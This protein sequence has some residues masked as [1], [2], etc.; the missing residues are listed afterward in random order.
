MTLSELDIQNK[1]CYIQLHV[2]KL[3]NMDKLWGNK[4]NAQI[5]E[6]K[7]DKCEQIDNQ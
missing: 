1:E 5:G 2:N 7:D 4:K 3:E 6:R